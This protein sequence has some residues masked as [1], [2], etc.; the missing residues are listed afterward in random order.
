L[1]PKRMPQ[2]PCKSLSDKGGS[3]EYVD[4]GAAAYEQRSLDIRVRNLTRNAAQMGYQLVPK[5]D[6]STTL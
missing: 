6:A 5:T 3:D 2:Q 4:R 1:F